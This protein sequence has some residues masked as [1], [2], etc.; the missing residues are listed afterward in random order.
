[1]LSIVIIILLHNN[2]NN[3]GPSIPATLEK[4]LWTMDGSIIILF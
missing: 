2:N 4:A 3:I 1:M